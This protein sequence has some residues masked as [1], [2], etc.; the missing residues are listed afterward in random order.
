[1]V[2]N[3]MI[4]LMIAVVLHVLSYTVFTL[5]ISFCCVLLISVIF[6]TLNTPLNLATMA[7]E[8]YIAICN[9]LRH[10]QICTV[11]KTY[12]LIGL[13]WVLSAIHVLPDLFILLATKPLAFF[14][15]SI[16]CVSDNVFDN[17]YIVQKKN[18]MYI[19]YLTFVWLTIVYT[20][21]KIMFVAKATN[22]DARKARSTIILH[23]IQ[24][25]MCMLTF[26]GPFL[27]SLLLEMFPLFIMD[28]RFLS[29]LVI[30]IMPR[31]ISPIVYGVRD[32]TFC[33]YLKRYLL[34]TMFNIRRKIQN[35]QSSGN[36]AKV[37]N[38]SI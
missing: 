20:Y 37:G 30:Q 9:P 10:A 4:Q 3:D 32:Q 35:L 1:M 25:L 17:P 22:S 14:Y 11:R 23:G 28:T 27:N 13:I 38:K 5:N 19:I 6:T 21:L 36:L 8:R 24:L 16:P 7:I 15:S 33:K 34:C 31:F 2:F 29:Y 12:I 26:V 18:I